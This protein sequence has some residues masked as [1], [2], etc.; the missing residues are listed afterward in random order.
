MSTMYTSISTDTPP[1]NDSIEKIAAA[2][3]SLGLLALLISWAGVNLPNP[4][5]WLYGSLALMFIGIVV[6]SARRYM[7]QPAGIK[8]HGNFFSGTVNRGLLGWTVGILV[9]GF[10]VCLYLKA[11]WL[12]L[13]SDGGANSGMVG[14]F[15]PLSMAMKGKPASQ[16]FVYGTLYTFAI[17]AFGIKFIMKYRHNKY[18]IL[19]TISIMFFQLFLAYLIPEI[20]EIL[21]PETATNYFGKDMKNMWP[22]NYDFFAEYQIVNMSRAGFLGYF[23]LILGLSMIFFISPVL[24]YLYGKRWYCS[25]VCGCGGLA[26]TA[27][28]PYRHLSDKSM[29]AWKLERWMIHGVLL[30]SF[31]MTIAIVYGYL[32]NKDTFWLNRTS[33]TILVSVLLI[34]LAGAYYFLQDKNDEDYD[35]KVTYIVGGSVIA[36]AI[37]L[38]INWFSGSSNA[39]FLQNYTFRSIYGMYI[40]AV[41]SGIIGVGFYPILGN[42]VWC[43]F[44]C[45]MAALMGVQQKLLSRFRI[46]TNGSQCISRGNCSTYCEMGIDVRAYA[47]KG[48]NIVRASCVGCGVC[49]AVC[50]R[51]VLRLENGSIDI[52]SKTSEMKVAMI[53]ESEVG[54]L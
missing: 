9:T 33:F 52:F 16:W 45:P 42:R 7:T 15:D 51:G 5:M 13:A 36:V 2:I 25:W 54:I 28:D 22:L 41:F 37:L 38:L 27:G 48:Q 18:H 31:V 19:R 4:A 39:F 3:G 46:T 34:G 20:L 40:G 49:S 26:E 23:F 17:I 44:G 6:F 50:P 35:M 14:F 10:Y 30:F 21:N 43:R 24:T 8:N 47:Q 11:E 1:Y 32:P 29:K 12:G 53:P